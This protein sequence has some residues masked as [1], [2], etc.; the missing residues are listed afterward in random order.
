[1]PSPTGNA[2]ELLRLNAA[3]TTLEY[4]PFSSLVSPAALT[5]VDD[6]NVTLTLGGTPSTALL[7]ATSLTLGWTGQLSLARGGT[8]A[9]LVD[10]GADRILFWDDSAN[11]VTWLEAGSGLSIS[12]TTLSAQVP[13][14]SL[15][16]ATA[17]NII[18]NA[19]YEQI[20]AWNSLAPSTTGLSLLSNL[21]N[22]TGGQLILNV[23]ISGTGG[24]GLTLGA[25]FANIITSSGTNIGALFSASGGATNTAI[26]VPSNSGRIGFG[27]YTPSELLQVVGTTQFGAPGSASGII[28]IS[29]STS[30]TITIQPAAAAGTYTLVLPTAQASGAQYLKNDGSGNLSWDSPAGAGTVTSFSSGD[31]SPLFTTSVATATTTPA[32]SFT[33]SNAGA[34]TWFGNNTG[35]AATPAYNSSGALTKS[36]DTNVTITLG[37]SPTTALLNAVSLTMGWTGQLSLARGGTGANLVDPNADRIM[38]WD[39]SAGA[40]TWLEVLAPLVISGTQIDFDE[41]ATLG[42][43]ARV[44]VN[45]NSGATVG[46]RR[47]LN[48]IEGTNITLTVADDAGNEEVDITI[49]AA[50]GSSVTFGA[51]NQIPFT[52][53][54]GTDFDYSAN[55]TF[56][57]S[58]LNV[59][60]GAVFNE[61]GAAVDFRIESDTNTNMFRVDGTNNRVYH[62]SNVYWDSSGDLYVN[63]RL[64]YYVY[65]G[66]TRGG[67][68]PTQIGYS[69]SPG[70]GYGFANANNFNTIDASFQRA[71]ASVIRAYNGGLGATGWATLTSNY[72]RFGT[73]SPESSVTA[74]VGTIYH[75][76]DG[77]TG[78]SL[79]IKESGTGNTGWVAV[80]P[81]TGSGI[82]R[83]VVSTSGSV[84]MGSTASTDYIYFVTGAHT[85]SLPAASGNTNRYTVKNNHSSAITVDTAGA[86]NVE[87]GAS[88]SVPAGSSVDLASDGT[89]WWIL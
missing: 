76:T 37:G 56:D 65:A 32:L 2:L 26:V 8:G 59:D 62:T 70:W 14:S 39:D 34:N 54:G 51:D 43:N 17:T 27:T 6:T 36:D 31:L 84:T 42:N 89:N 18:D 85:L 5:K 72:D 9:N 78:T 75:R 22:P 16:A 7:Q 45:K 44:A 63:D 86:E 77:G 1:M 25:S 30:G 38:F 58:S 40:V 11:A 73:G 50:S 13:I 82:T 64:T 68:H 60:G 74:D 35:G 80:A 69:V 15:L 88:I 83:S 47:R 12:G 3:E 41:T 48:F 21:T 4:V 71:S 29:G 33:L 46:T 19:G 79:Y 66:D 67:W 10:P 55:F 20:W 87:G 28:K 57:G 81:G 24:S 23:E 52:N 53:A 61:G 49:T